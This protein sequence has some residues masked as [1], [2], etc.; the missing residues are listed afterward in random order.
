MKVLIVGFGSIGQRH[1]KVLQ[2]MGHAVSIVSQQQL[3][4]YPVYRSVAEALAAQAFAYVV[5][6]NSTEQ[7]YDTVNT[8]A[9]QGYQGTVLVEKPLFVTVEKVPPNH[10]KQF[11]VAYN[12]RF[13]PLMQQLKKL[14]KTAKVVSVSVY[15]GQY[16]PDWRP[17][18][19]YRQSYSADSRRGGGVL[20]DLSH[21]LDY[22]IW[23]F[24]AVKTLTALGGHFSQLDVK[25]DDVYGVLLQTTQ[26]PLVTVQLNYLDHNPKRELII[27][28]QQHTIEAD[29]MAN[30]LTVDG[31]STALTVDRNESYRQQHEAILTGQAAD[32]CSAEQAITVLEVIA[33]IQQANQ[34]REWR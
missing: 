7:H 12:L 27:H 22:I 9:E 11:Y 10:F 33:A 2:T 31:Q 8:L 25:S 24:G 21:E 28:T 34:T 29:F 5:V 1:A 16:L 18:Q 17:Q 19:D 14:L 15:T 4:D 6:A 32:C 23:L 13:H 26:V 30:T 20:H 3:A